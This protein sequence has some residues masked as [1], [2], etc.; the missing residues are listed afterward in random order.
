VEV[1]ASVDAIKYICKY[2]YKG[3]DRIM[4]RLESDHDEVN[5]YLQACYIGLTE[6]CWWIFEYCTHE[7]FPNVVKLAVYLLDQHAYTFNKDDLPEQRAAYRENAWSTLMAFFDWNKELPDG[8]T[9]YKY[10]EMP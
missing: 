1:C 6:G 2:I 9:C 10:S 3:P 8:A 4:L 7:E 5:L